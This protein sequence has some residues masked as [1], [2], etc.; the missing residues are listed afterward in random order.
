[1]GS[2]ATIT[3]FNFGQASN[4]IIVYRTLSLSMWQKTKTIKNRGQSIKK[5]IFSSPLVTY[6]DEFT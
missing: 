2:K 1:M 5:R 3:T 4:F 6:P